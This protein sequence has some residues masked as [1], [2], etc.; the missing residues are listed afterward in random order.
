MKY[1]RIVIPQSGGPEALQVVEADLPEPAPGEVRVKVLSAGVLL[2][3]VMWQEGK[4]PG[5]PKPPFIPGYDL[6]GVVDRLGDGVSAPG[7]GQTV[8]ALVQPGGYTQYAS[9]PPEKLV[10]VPE[11]LD[12]AEVVCLTVNYTTGYQI[13]KRVAKLTPGK[14]VLVHGAAGGTGSA[15][16]D[17][18]KVLGLEMYGTASKPKHD[19][20]ASL[21]ATPIDYRDE[22]FVERIRSLTGDGVDLVVDHIGGAH[23]KRSFQTLRAG[24]LLI[25]TASTA[26]IWGESTTLELLWGLIQLPL[27]NSLPN[28][29]SAMLFDL[30]RFNKKNP[31]WYAQD[32]K[33]LMGYLAEGEIKP[34][35]ARQMPL[36]EVRQAQE[37]LLGAKV[38]GK[39]VLMCN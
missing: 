20:V 4:V 33:T 10:P 37:L 38:R 24:G 5:G 18:G 13:F 31:A 16:L 30:V 12:P 25:S 3:D 29:K 26:Q 28:K 7:V 8:A 32:L 9:L 39:I 17:L 23:L 1:R 34:V 19:L 21:G 35:I 11:G 22:D 2:A 14:R 6:V 27:W 36:V 15:L